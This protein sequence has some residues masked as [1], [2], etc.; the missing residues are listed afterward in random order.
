M[1]STQSSAGVDVVLGTD[2]LGGMHRHQ[3][4]ELAI[5]AQVQS[6]AQVLA[7]ATTTAARLLQREGELGV[8]APGALGDLLV[9]DGD[10]LADVTVLAR[11]QES[12]R[13]VVQGGRVVHQRA[14]P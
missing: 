10:P 11:P 5:R 13:H 1:D 4:E 2:L 8:L 6:S 9:V 14:H 7:S 3:S 12:L